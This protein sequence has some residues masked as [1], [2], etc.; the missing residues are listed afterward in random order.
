MLVL[1]VLGLSQD[2]FDRLTMRTLFNI[3][4]GKRINQEEKEWE[5]RMTMERHR[6]LCFS[7]SMPHMKEEYQKVSIQEFMPMPWDPDYEKHLAKAQKKKEKKTLSPEDVQ[8]T[9]KNL[10]KV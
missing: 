4:E 8:K 1:G 10:N 3:I 9:L 2:E 7:I 6:E 5:F